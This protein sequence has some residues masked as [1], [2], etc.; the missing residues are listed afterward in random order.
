MV[1]RRLDQAV[2]SLAVII[3]DTQTRFQDSI[4]F[5][6]LGEVSGVPFRL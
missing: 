2:M 5:K 1:A 4:D 6:S 3:C